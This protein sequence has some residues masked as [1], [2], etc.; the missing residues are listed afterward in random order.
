MAYLVG[1]REARTTIPCPHCGA[2]L[3]IRRTCWDVF[4]QCSG[5]RK[6]FKVESF[7]QQMDEA[8]EEF[9]ANVY[10]DRT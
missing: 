3:D 9:L 8:M 2:P 1:P 6:A 5:C 7:A 10:A 4:M